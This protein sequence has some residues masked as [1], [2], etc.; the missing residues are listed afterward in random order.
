MAAKTVVGGSTVSADQLK[1]LLRQIADGSLSG[2]HIQGLLE[3]RNPFE[4]S[5]DTQAQLE[6]ACTLCAEAFGITIDPTSVIVPERQ[7]GI[8]RLIVVPKGMTMN[9]LISYFRTKFNV[10]LYVEDFDKNVTKNDR[11]N[12]ETYAIWVA[13]NVEAD[14]NLKNLSADQLAEQKIPGITLLERLI[15]ELLYF[16]E[17]GNHLDVQNVTLCAGSRGS[18]GH[19]PSV[20]WRAGSRGLY[21]GW[22]GADYR[23]DKL[24]ARAVVS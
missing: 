23:H 6:R 9:Q 14:E 13:D 24:R 19:V 15:Y 12:S 5:M 16:S 4:I 10:W 1:D 21:V 20:Y 3:H 8:D 2:Y 18:G 22:D 11:T 17:T 7:A